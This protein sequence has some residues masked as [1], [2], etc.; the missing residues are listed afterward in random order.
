MLDELYFRKE[1]KK[2]KME[3]KGA[4][5]EPAKLF[6]NNLYGTMASSTDSR[7]KIAFID[8]DNSLKFEVDKPGFIYVD[9]DTD[10]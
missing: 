1:L 4:I 2:I 5:R 10:G 8:S 3:N 6:L 9:T 7:Y